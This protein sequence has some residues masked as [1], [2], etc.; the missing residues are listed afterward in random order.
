MEIIM[1]FFKR[2]TIAGLV[3]CGAMLGINAMNS[4]LSQEQRLTLQEEAFSTI[5]DRD[6]ELE[7]LF[8]KVESDPFPSVILDE[9]F[10]CVV[11][12]KENIARSNWYAKIRSTQKRYIRQEV[13]AEV[14]KNGEY[15]NSNQNRVFDCVLKSVGNGIEALVCNDPEVNK[16]LKKITQKYNNKYVC[17]PGYPDGDDLTYLVAN[18]VE[19]LYRGDCLLNLVKTCTAVSQNILKR[20]PKKIHSK[21]EVFGW[22]VEGAK[23]VYGNLWH[24]EYD[25]VANLLAEK[26]LANLKAEDKIEDEI[27]EKMVKL[28]ALQQET[29]ERQK[30][31]Q[32][33]LAQLQK[34]NQAPLRDIE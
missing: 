29:A 27:K 21:E 5:I 6:K 1:I 23:H 34:A 4:K 7:P 9:S 17:Y 33:K 20:I 13:I 10:Q 31:L 14:L 22:I 18:Q 2:I 15:E 8:L 3:L 19:Y 11:F 32:E 26:T 28:Q 25:V 16:I 12:N 24:Q 30:I